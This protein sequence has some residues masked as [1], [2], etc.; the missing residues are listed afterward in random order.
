MLIPQELINQIYNI[1][2]YLD[3]KDTLD[4]IKGFNPK[5]KK[6]INDYYK[7][8]FDSWYIYKG[9]K[10]AYTMSQFILYKHKYHYSDHYSY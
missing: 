4:I 5:Y 3:F 1:K 9:Y 7:H 8:K 10:P 2:Y 6:Y